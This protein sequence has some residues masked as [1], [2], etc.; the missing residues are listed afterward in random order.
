MVIEVLAAARSMG[1][2]SVVLRASQMGGNNNP[3]GKGGFEKGAPSRNPGGRPRRHIGDLS[4]EARRYAK[5]ALDTLVKITKTGM[6]RNQLA[7]ARELLDRGYGRPV[8]ALDLLSA[9]KKLSELSSDELAAFEAR[10]MTAA[11]DDAAE[12]AQGELSLH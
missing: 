10:L 7:A 8:Q 4:R 3:T 1:Y 2:V 9:G 12:P 11:A 5:L 6:E